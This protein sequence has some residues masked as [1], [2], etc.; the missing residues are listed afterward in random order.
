MK[1][2]CVSTSQRMRVIRLA[3]SSRHR[4]EPRVLAKPAA[5]L[6][7][8]LAVCDHDVSGEI[9]RAA[10]ERR[11]DAVRVHGD[12]LLLEEADL[13]HVEAARRDDAQSLVPARV[14]RLANFPDEPLVHTG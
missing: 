10:D 8:R 2:T 1:S 3:R 11:A 5:D 9:V 12:T 13:L 6:C 4:F 7:R 14:E